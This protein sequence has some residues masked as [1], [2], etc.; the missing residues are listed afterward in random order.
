M[1]GYG[2]TS[3]MKE[4]LYPLERLGLTMIL[5]DIILILKVSF[6]SFVSISLLCIRATLTAASVA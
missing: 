1:L 4:A 5:E 2:T 3:L 6:I